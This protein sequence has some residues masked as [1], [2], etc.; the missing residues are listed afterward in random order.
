MHASSTRTSSLL[1]TYFRI[2]AFNVLSWSLICLIGAVGNYV[3]LVQHHVQRT[4]VSV[5]WGWLSSH[6]LMMVFSSCLGIF[7]L[8]KEHVLSSSKRIIFLFLSLCL[9]FFPLEMAH[10]TFLAMRNKNLPMNIEQFMYVVGRTDQFTW[11]LEFAWFSG[12]FAVVIAIR[13]WDLGQKRAAVLQQTQTDNLLL[14]LQLEQQKLH[15]LRQQ[16][17]PHFIFNALNAISALVR[18]NEKQIALAGI[19]SLSDLFRYALN[20]S[21]HEWVRF[22]DE[23][24]FIRDYLALQKLRYGARL[25]F[26]IEG[27][28]PSILQGDCPPLLLQALVENCL[29]H[30]LDCHEAASEISLKFSLCDEQLSICIRN[31]SSAEHASNPGLGLGLSQT[32]TRLELLY[33]SS[34]HLHIQKTAEEFIVELELPLFKPE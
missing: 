27:V 5:F 12:A 31:P 14:S 19:H 32:K 10:I 33:K 11:F 25:Q 20:A 13:I 16:L 18:S 28:N 22:E 24:N 26:S 15:N 34:A 9:F 29:R 8:H 3:D 23:L 21:K 7:L 1:P 6:L 17:E 2:A 4:F 30:G